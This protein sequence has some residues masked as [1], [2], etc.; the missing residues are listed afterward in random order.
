[1]FMKDFVVFSKV[2]YDDFYVMSYVCMVTSLIRFRKL[3][4]LQ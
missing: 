4:T 2:I 3:G 1:M